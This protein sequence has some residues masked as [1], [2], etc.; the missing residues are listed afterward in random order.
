[1]I[2]LI[3]MPGDDL[4]L[5][6]AFTKIRQ[7]KSAH[8]NTPN[9]AELIDFA[10]SCNDTANRRHVMLLQPRQ[11][12]DRVVAGYAGYWGEQRQQRPLGNKRR[13]LGAKPPGAR[14]LMHNDAAS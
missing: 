6:E 12:N 5:F 9:S 7:V 4:C 14:C 13:N 1:M 3:D 11:W 8:R 2:T 10:R